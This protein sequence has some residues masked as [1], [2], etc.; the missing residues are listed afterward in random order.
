MY[1]YILYDQF[2]F[3]LIAN[4]VISLKMQYFGSHVALHP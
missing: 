2:F 1:V 3:Y 4:E